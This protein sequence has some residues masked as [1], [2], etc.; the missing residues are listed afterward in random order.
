MKK[1][2]S[3]KTSSLIS[4]TSYL[5]FTLIEL[6][7]VV[8]IIAILAGMLLPALNAAREKA[9]AIGCTSNLKQSML[10]IQLY[11]N[12]SNGYVTL[13]DSR[14]SWA[15]YVRAL[16][17]EAKANA[18]AKAFGCNYSGPNTDARAKVRGQCP[19][20][21][22]YGS[23]HYQLPS[24]VWVKGTPNNANSRVL[25]PRKIRNPSSFFV[26]GDTYQSPLSS[27]DSTVCQNA[28]GPAQLYNLDP[29]GSNS[30]ISGFHI[31]HAN[32]GSVGF[33][34]GHSASITAQRFKELIYN[35]S[36]QHGSSTSISIKVVNFAGVYESVP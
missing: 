21:D 5:N 32:K 24:L 17:P 28:G 6:L 11:D 10:Y 30:N 13:N 26:L 22:I 14:G 34:D 1:D 18:S 7:I 20:H 33:S 35:D 31:R 3:P 2:R 8:A 23:R 16:M 12:S 9:Q 29:K 15:T 36:T 4:P 27:D 25:V 19:Y